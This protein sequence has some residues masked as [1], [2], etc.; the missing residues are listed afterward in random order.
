[1]RLLLSTMP[2][3]NKS[4]P[5]RNGEPVEVAMIGVLKVVT[6]TGLPKVVIPTGPPKVVTLSGVLGVVTLTGPL[7]LPPPRMPKSLPSGLTDVPGIVK[8]RSRTIR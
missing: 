6:L 4:P 7:P 2:L 5:P 1:M 8:R 3:L